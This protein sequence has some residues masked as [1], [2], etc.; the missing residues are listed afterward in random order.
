MQRHWK[1]TYFAALNSFKTLKTFSGAP[2][3]LLIFAEVF[4]PKSHSSSVGLEIMQKQKFFVKATVVYRT[5]PDAHP[6][7]RRQW[8][9]LHWLKW[10]PQEQLYSAAVPAIPRKTWWNF[11]PA[12]WN[13]TGQ[14]SR[15]INGK[16]WCTF[17]RGKIHWC[18]SVGKTE[19][20]ELL[21]M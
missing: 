9:D 8:I 17:I 4:C 2:T 7:K 6:N 1:Q 12:R 21:K 18:T 13:W 15:L 3:V 14:L 11:G 5:S 20:R 16:V 10:R 19:L